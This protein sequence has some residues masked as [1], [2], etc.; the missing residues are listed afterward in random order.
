MWMRPL[1]FYPISCP[2]NLLTSLSLRRALTAAVE[3]EAGRECDKREGLN[4]RM[5]DKAAL[6]IDMH[7]YPA[8]LVTLTW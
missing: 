8:K 1:Q 3:G 6:S 4:F 2:Y 7:Q 5:P